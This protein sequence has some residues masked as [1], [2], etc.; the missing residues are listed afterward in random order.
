MDQ[1]NDFFRFFVKTMATKDYL[2][3]R[4]WY[5]CFSI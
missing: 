1:K 2:A 4:L 5:L 3:K